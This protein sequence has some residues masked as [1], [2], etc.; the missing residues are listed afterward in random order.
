MLIVAKNFDKWRP[1]WAGRINGI[2]PEDPALLPVD[3]Q[4]TCA[5]WILLGLKLRFFGG[6]KSFF[7]LCFGFS[8]SK[9]YKD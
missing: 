5:S 9:L 2:F 4:H 8:I 1:F 3:A 7:Y 6:S